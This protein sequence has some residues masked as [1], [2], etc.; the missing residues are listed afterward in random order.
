M[1]V[2]MFNLFD[3]YNRSWKWPDVRKEHL[4]TQP[5]C[6][7]CGRSDHIE[8]HHIE[9]YHINPDRELDLTNLIS[10]CSKHCHLTFGHLMDYKSWNK[11]VVDTC[12]TYL[13]KL[14]A[15]PYNENF[16]QKPVN[17]NMFYCW[18]Y[19]LLSLWDY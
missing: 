7:A 14:Q 19:K 2:K 6:Q 13:S 8:V 11:D 4:K 10:L 1:D 16:Y 9:P 15:R 12:S 5:T 17:G 18:L 3:R